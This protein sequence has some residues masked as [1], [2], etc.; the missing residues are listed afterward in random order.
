MDNRTG[1]C[2]IVTGSIGPHFEPQLFRTKKS[3]KRYVAEINTYGKAHDIWPAFKPVIEPRW[4][5]DMIR[6][7]VQP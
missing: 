4:E 6:M 1:D 7:K 5:S 2:Y 3:A